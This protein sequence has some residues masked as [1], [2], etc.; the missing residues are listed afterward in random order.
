MPLREAA[1]RFASIGTCHVDV[2]EG[3]WSCTL[4]GV[5]DAAGRV[6]AP[7]DLRRRFIELVNDENLRE[8]LEVRTGSLRNVIVAL[9]FGALAQKSATTS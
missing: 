8:K 4:D 1:Y 3:Q 9:A 2:V 7:D 6:P 5:K